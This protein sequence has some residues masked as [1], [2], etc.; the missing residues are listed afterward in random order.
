MTR[1]QRRLA[2]I[3]AAD[4]AG[5]SRLMGVDESG[6]LAAL[7][8]H[9]RELIDPKI[10]E[11]GGRIVKTTGDGL[12]LEFP[13]VVEAV[14]CAVDVQRAMRAHN[15]RLSADRRIELR[16]GINVG[17]IILDGD[18]I[19]GDGVNVAARL[20]GLSEPGGICVSK[21]VRDQVVDKLS[22][23]FKGL[24]EQEVKNIARPIDV[25]RVE[26]DGVSGN[27][28]IVRRIAPASRGWRLI[29][30]AVAVACIAVA[31][32][33]TVPYLR[34][35]TTAAAPAMSVAVL[36]FG[37]KGGSEHE[38]RLADDVTR[39][40]AVRLGRTQPLRV[41]S[42]RLTDGYKG[43]SLDT[44]AAG[45]ELS[46]RYLV[47]G[48][49]RRA[50]DAMVV[51]AQVTDSA[52]GKQLWADRFE[53][54][55]SGFDQREGILLA[56][57]TRRAYEAV[58]DSEIRRAGAPP[59]PNAPAIEYVLHGHHLW[60]R[61]PASLVARTEAAR[62]FDKA[63]EIDPNLGSA[64]V[65]R[66]FIV[67]YALLLDSGADR[68]ALIDEVDQLT[69]RAIKLDQSDARAWWLRGAALGYQRRWDAALDANAQA[70][71]LDPTDM[72]AMG[73]RAELLMLAG[74][75]DDAIA[76]TERILQLLPANSLDR[77]WPV[78]TRCRV[79]VGLGR[80]DDGIPA[81]EKAVANHDWWLLHVYLL[82]AYTKRGQV[83][84]AATEKAALLKLRPGFSIAEFQALQLSDSPDWLLQHEMRV[85]P[86][87]RKAGIPETNGASLK[88]G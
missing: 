82:A 75:S 63:L 21:V 68:A 70:L 37:A 61:D 81:C 11:Y 79:F 42:S 60:Q 45:R 59:A 73:S 50:G 55:A 84:K 8:S 29:A 35:S 48:D 65:T 54:P 1:E 71:R 69:S 12:L 43:K 31:T 39:D 87:L 85:Y 2:A 52:T 83:D 25:Y 28:G 41:T 67:F 64:L 24:G 62:W 16:I 76:E 5:Y 7:K 36:P 4:V 14:R 57:V 44:G 19:Y 6:T 30:A 56:Q 66:I 49:I 13:S 86:E 88:S 51:D 23:G 33:F 27:A 15:A 53:G 34:K 40:L 46:V 80:Y 78:Q 3:V 20:E 38:Q 17:D 26:L 72:G 18:D 47:H 74:R 77:G 32:A 10:A 58:I 9:R 22:F